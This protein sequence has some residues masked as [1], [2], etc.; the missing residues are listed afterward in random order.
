MLGGNTN[1]QRQI[2]LAHPLDV[3]PQTYQLARRRIQ[4]SDFRQIPHQFYL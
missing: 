2:Q 3:T 4:F 1:F